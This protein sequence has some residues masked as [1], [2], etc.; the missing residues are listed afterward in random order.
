[1]RLL[2]LE[3]HNKIVAIPKVLFEESR[4]MSRESHGR[5]MR[6]YSLETMSISSRKVLFQMAD[7]V[8]LLLGVTGHTTVINHDR[9]AP[10]VNFAIFDGFGVCAIFFF[11]NW[12]VSWIH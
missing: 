4:T 2:E 6:R 5:N 11:I 3:S 9:Y 1:M 10:W 12:C 7:D 8:L